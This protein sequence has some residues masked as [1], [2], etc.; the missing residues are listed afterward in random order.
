MVPKY[1]LLSDAYIRFEI[2]ASSPDEARRLWH[3]WL[4][5]RLAFRV[6]DHVQI[7]VPHPE[8]TVVLHESHTLP[9][10]RRAPTGD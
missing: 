1:T 2:E 8:A 5:N 6:E 4:Q 10:P 7:T 9:P 3:T